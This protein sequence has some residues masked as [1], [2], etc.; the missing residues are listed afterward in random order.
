MAQE[1]ISHTGGQV[2]ANRKLAVFAWG[3]E[4]ENHHSPVSLKLSLGCLVSK[5]TEPG[6]QPAGGCCVG[7]MP[8]EHINLLGFIFS[9]LPALLCVFLYTTM[10]TVQRKANFSPLRMFHHVPSPPG[11]GLLLQPE[12]ANDKYL[13]GGRRRSHEVLLKEQRK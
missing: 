4:A 9:E 11:P 10:G 12:M 3:G 2:T 5:K 8:L 13:R 1:L 6:V 7:Q